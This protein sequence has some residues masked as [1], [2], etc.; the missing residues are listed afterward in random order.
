MIGGDRDVRD[1][2]FDHAKHRREHASD[3]SN[4][5]TIL[6]PCGRQRVLVPEQL[7]CAVDQIDVQGMR[8]G[9]ASS[10]TLSHRRGHDQD[11]AVAD[12][13]CDPFLLL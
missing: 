9:H 6:I 1:P 11:L 12:Q 8:P 13:S 10:T 4:F 7:V 2:A 5:A 3:S